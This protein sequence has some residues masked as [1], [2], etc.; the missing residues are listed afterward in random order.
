[1]S[2]KNKGVYILDDSSFERHP[3]TGVLK[4]KIMARLAF[5]WPGRAICA[6]PFEAHT[7]IDFTGQPG[8]CSGLYYS[9]VF[10][11]GK[12]EYFVKKVDE[13]IEVSPVHAQYYQLTQQQKSELEGKIKVGLASASQAVADLELLLHDYRKYKEFLRYFGYRTRKEIEKEKKTKIEE[14]EDDELFLD[15]DEKNVKKRLDNHSLKAVFIDQVDVH[16]GEGISMRSIVQRWPTLISDFMRMSDEDLDVNNVMKKLDVSRAEAVVLVTKNKLFL[17]W[18][19]IFGSEIKSRYR[20]IKEL[21]NSRKKS[22]DEYRDWLRPIIARHKMLKEGLATPGGRAGA[23]IS[24]VTSV[25]HA[26][27][28]A[29]IVL[30]VWKDFTPSEI[31]KGGGGE[32]LGRLIAEGKITP[33]DKW[34]K[35][36]LIFGRKYGLINAYP[37]ITNEWVKNKLNEFYDNR[38]LTRNVPYYSFFIITLDR[39]N[40]RTPTGGEVEDGV[41]DV[42]LVVMSQNVL[43][44]KLLELAA[45]QEELNKYID[46]L[47][48]IEHKIEGK[49]EKIEEKNYFENIKNFLNKISF[50]MEFYKK[51]PYEKDF[52]D[53]LTNIYYAALVG[54]RYNQ[55]VNFIKQKIGMGA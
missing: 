1:M 22:V 13:W 25:G 33:Y 7:A 6:C 32:E 45:K 28:S 27:S 54:I 26:T 38:W 15:E 3:F 29:R 30:W 49:R 21:V 47:L 43:F 9:L 39:T 48:G 5:E 37:W 4:N 8:S 16:T 42:N 50:G 11:L 34:T 41:F 51:G 20:R 35:K 2:E 44:V 46:E 12:W 52:F 19:N 18:K 36:N 24:P 40:I 17:E 31:F 14:I 23:L 10:Q 55:I 53:R